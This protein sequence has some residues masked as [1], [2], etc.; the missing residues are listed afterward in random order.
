MQNETVSLHRE[1]PL[2]TSWDNL[3]RGTVIPPNWQQS[4]GNACL[5]HLIKHSCA[6]EHGAWIFSSFF[7]LF[8][9]KQF[10]FVTTEYL[11]L[12]QILIYFPKGKNLHFFLFCQDTLHRHRLCKTKALST[13]FQHFNLEFPWGFPWLFLES[14]FS[15]LC[16]W[17]EKS[18]SS[19]C[20]S[21]VPP[22]VPAYLL[23]PESL[24]N[25]S[26]FFFCLLVY[27]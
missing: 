19:Y 6:S 8:S 5:G 3:D 21:T 17:Y 2:C 27:L 15:F 12:I 13:S 18:A 11:L 16:L 22:V 9:F 4:L 20:Q 23:C 1:Q 24:S 25:Y 26:S 14:H 10:R 7:W